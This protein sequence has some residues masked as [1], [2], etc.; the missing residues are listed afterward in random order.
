MNKK[1]IEGLEVIA[2]GLLTIVAGLK[3]DNKVDTTVDTVAISEVERPVD[4]IST[5]EVSDET[6]PIE[7]KSSEVENSI[8]TEG[9]TEAQLSDMT[10]NELKKLAKEL[11]LSASGTRKELVE[12]ILSINEK[13]QVSNVPDN[14]ADVPSSKKNIAL[15]GKKQSESI[16]EEEPEPD[17]EEE[18]EPD[19]DE[20]EVDE[21]IDSVEAKILKETEDME[22][23]EIRG[24]LADVG[25]PTKGKRQSL[26]SRLIDAVEEGLIELDEEDSPTD[27]EDAEED[28]SGDITESMTELRRNA[29]EE[30]CDDTTEQFESGEITKEDIIDFLTDFDEEKYNANTLKKKTDEELLEEYFTAIALMIDDS[31]NVVEEG[32]YLINDTPYCCGHTLVY[33]QKKGTF[34]CE[35]CGEEYEAE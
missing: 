34:I 1:I 24:L 31:G 27:T 2:T 20:A 21:E 26:I 4:N 17:D 6:E 8:E 23:D 25:M 3:E 16:E 12:K 22:D 18:F 15:I 19:E 5:G 7:K 14:K 13:G 9:Y 32:A 35:H 11:G 30:L 28:N 10:Y 33:N 29:Y